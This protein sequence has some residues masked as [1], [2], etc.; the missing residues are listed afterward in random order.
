M[1]TEIKTTSKVNTLTGDMLT[2]RYYVR[3]LPADLLLLD[4][5]EANEEATT[6]KARGL[7]VRKIHVCDIEHYGFVNV[8]YAIK[9]QDMWLGG[10][11]R[12][13]KG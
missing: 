11:R 7:A 1:T 5:S 8:R 3:N 10:G 2:T 13:H 12:F 4:E 6:Y 9:Y